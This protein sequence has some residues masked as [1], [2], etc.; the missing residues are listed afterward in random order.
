MMKYKWLI[1]FSVFVITLIIVAIV[2]TDSEDKYIKEI[3]LSELTEKIEKKDSFILFIKQTDC[4]HCKSFTPKFVS[5]LKENNLTSYA[6]NIT[7]LSEEDMKEYK[8]MFDVEG[9]PTVLFYKD[10]NKNIVRIDGDQ[11]KDAIVSKFKAVDFVK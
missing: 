2:F 3:S 11:D 9:T 10:G 6:L 8:K 5:A 4:S 1:L 7:N